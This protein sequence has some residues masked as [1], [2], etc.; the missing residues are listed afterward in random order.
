MSLLEAFDLNKSRAEKKACCDYGFHLGVS[1]YDENVAKEM[2]TLV[3]EKKINSF[4]AYMAPLKEAQMISDEDLVSVLDKCKQLGAIGLVHAENGQL[5]SRKQKEIKELGI[6]GPEGHLLSRPE[7]LE[8]DATQRAICI[9]NQVNCPLYIVNVT[10]KSSALII[11]NAKRAGSVVFG[12]PIAASLCTDG[13]HYFNKCWRHSAGHVMSPPLRDDPTTPGYLMDFLSNGDLE[14]A[15]SAHCVFNTNQK[16]LG[17][18]DFN[19]IPTGNF[20]EY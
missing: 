5:I 20:F 3:N 4:K 11:S 16:A 7:N 9:A 8:A 15:S 18:S 12:E 10:S 6:T 19:L 14:L 13:T 17:K 1:K 2:E